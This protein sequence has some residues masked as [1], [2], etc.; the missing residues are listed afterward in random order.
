MSLRKG[1]VS[2]T[3]KWKMSLL[4]KQQMKNI[5]E[6]GTDLFCDVSLLSIDFKLK[7]LDYTWILIVVIQK[8]HRKIGQT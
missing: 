2:L 6:Q 8:S 3:K 4:Q 5:S 1:A 7:I